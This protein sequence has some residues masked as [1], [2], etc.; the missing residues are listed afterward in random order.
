M[1]ADGATIDEIP[2]ERF[3]GPATVVDVARKESEPITA[4]ELAAAADDVRADDILLVRTGWGDRY[5]RDEY[6]RYPWLAADAGDWLLEKGVKLLAVDTPSPD[7]PARRD[8]T[9]GTS[10]RSTGRCCQRTCSSRNISVSR[11]RWPAPGRPS[12]DFRCP[13]AAATVRPLGSSRPRR[14]HRNSSR[15]AIVD[16][17]RHD[18]RHI[19]NGTCLSDRPGK[20]FYCS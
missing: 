8:P 6:E 20:H 7:R 1:I 19:G 15:A 17:S 9:T 5:G 16:T 13:S 18:R 2:L 12:S 11:P 3:A 10:I 4:A 14:P